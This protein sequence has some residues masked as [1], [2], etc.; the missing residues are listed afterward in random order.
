[1][2]VALIATIGLPGSGKTLFCLELSQ[3]HSLVQLDDGYKEGK[4]SDN[5]TSMELLV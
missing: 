3:S 5:D 1:M 4:T 2:K